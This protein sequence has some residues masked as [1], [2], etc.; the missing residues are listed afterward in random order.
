M[1]VP[2]ALAH[3]GNKGHAF[4]PASWSAMSMTKAARELAGDYRNQGRQLQSLVDSNTAVYALGFVD[5]EQ[6]TCTLPK[7]IV[8]GVK[9]Q[10]T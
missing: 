8:T 3:P 2:S 9:N 7:H 5:R 6:N 4:A 10:Q 1:N